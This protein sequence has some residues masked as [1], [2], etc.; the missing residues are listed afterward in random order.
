MHSGVNSEGVFVAKVDCVDERLLWFGVTTVGAV[1]D[2]VSSQQLRVKS[3][4]MENRFE[5]I[6]PRGG[7]MGPHSWSDEALMPAA[8]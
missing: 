5:L 7:V 6:V 1:T 3:N 2:C 4:Q 8:R